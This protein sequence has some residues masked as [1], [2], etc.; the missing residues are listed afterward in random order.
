MMRLVAVQRWP[1]VPKP[2]HS[3]P[4]MARSRLAS[5]STIMGFLPPSSSEQCLKL[6]AAVVPTMRP[7]SLDPVREIARTSGCSVSGPPTLDPNPVTMLITPRGTPASVSA[8]TRLKVESGVSCAGLMT[9]V[10]PQTIAGS[11]FHEGIAMGKFHGVIMPTTPERLAHRHGELVG[12]LGGRGG[13]E[14]AAA[15]AGHVVG[16]VDGFLHVAAS[17]FE[18]L[19][20]F[21]GHVA[22]VFFL[23]L[24][25]H[26][27][28]AIDDFG[29]AGSGDQAPLVEG[30]FGG[31]DGGVHIGL[32]R[33]LEDADHV[34]RVGGIAVLEGLAGRRFNPFAIDEVLVNLGVRGRAE[35]GRT[36][37]KCRLP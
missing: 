6:L 20:H 5:S 15:F 2:P 3:P 21:A 30:V 17:F 19:A 7:T 4:S 10:L 27:G 36:G 14:H 23:A 22:G 26:F 32:A 24:D 35:D 37:K 12:Q 29:A 25:Q 11:S 8:R 31:F 28:G 33:L 13:A 34:A 1:V 9:Q 16:R 18:N